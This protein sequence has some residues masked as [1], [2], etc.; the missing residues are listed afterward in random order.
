MSAA[1]RGPPRWP[2]FASFTPR[3][4]P[5]RIR[6]AT[7]SRR[8]RSVASPVRVMS[9]ALLARSALVAARH[10]WWREDAN[11]FQWLGTVRL[12]RVAGSDR[13]PDRNPGFQAVSYTHLTLPTT[14]I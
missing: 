12:R 1:D 13:N 7:S 5:T 9:R 4:T 2:A 8:A 10:D 6:L 14:R 11:Q 3:I